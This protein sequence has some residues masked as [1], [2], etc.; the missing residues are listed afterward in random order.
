MG[1]FRHSEERVLR[2]VESIFLVKCTFYDTYE[3]MDPSTTRG[4]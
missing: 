3:K 4:L 2:D 1:L